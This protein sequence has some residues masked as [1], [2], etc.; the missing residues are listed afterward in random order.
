MNGVFLPPI[1]LALPS[2]LAAPLRWGLILAVAAL[3]EIK[4]GTPPIAFPPSQKYLPIPGDWTGFS[5]LV[6]ML[7]IVS[8]YA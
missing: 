8:T 6:H 5:V 7:V 2:V 4:M 1:R 3:S